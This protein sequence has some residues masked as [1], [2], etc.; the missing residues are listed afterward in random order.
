MNEV[1]RR[2]PGRPA[3]PPQERKVHFT[4]R[5]EKRELVLAD[6][7]AEKLGMTRTEYVRHAIM[8]LN[9]SVRDAS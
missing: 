7:C 4:G 8:R 2:G 1:T 6:E 3:L 5:I 9:A